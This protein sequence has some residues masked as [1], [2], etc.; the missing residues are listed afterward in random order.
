MI[1]SYD[2]TGHARRMAIENTAIC[3]HRFKDEDPPQFA[4]CQDCKSQ[5]LRQALPKKTGKTKRRR[6]AAHT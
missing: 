6:E 3:T 1:N 4:W 5:F 2:N